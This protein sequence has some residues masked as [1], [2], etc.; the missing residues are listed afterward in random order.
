[1]LGCS[2]RECRCIENC[3]KWDEVVVSNTVKYDGGGVIGAGVLIL[4]IVNQT[5][6]DFDSRDKSSR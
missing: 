2:M 4:A 3:Q 1:M 5:L 6:C